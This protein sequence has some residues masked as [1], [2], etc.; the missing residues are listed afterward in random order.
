MTP[1]ISSTQ[2]H[3]VAALIAEGPNTGVM[4]VL[5]SAVALPYTPFQ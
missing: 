2:W 3:S 4:G 5:Q 1:P